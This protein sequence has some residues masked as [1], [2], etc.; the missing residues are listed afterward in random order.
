MRPGSLSKQYN[1]CGNLACRCKDPVKP[2]R[3]GPYYQLS[4]SRRGKSKTEF[5][6]KEMAPR[7]RRELKNYKRFVKLREELI[8][9]SRMALT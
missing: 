7:I 3:H 2:K 4:Y 1:V 6:R 9:L 5:I 8:D